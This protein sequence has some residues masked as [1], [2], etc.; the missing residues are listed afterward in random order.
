MGVRVPPPALFS[1][2]LLNMATISREQ[3]APLHERIK[4]TVSPSD[5]N[6]SFESAL[7]KYAKNANIPGFR[8]GMVPTG[9]VKKMYG[10]GVFTEEVLRKIEHELMQYLQQ[11]NISYLAQPLPED[12]NDAAQISYTEPKDYTFSFEIGLKPT[13]TIPDLAK[14]KTTLSL[15][16][17]TDEMVNEEIDRLRQ[18]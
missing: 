13:F 11:E 1:Q 2:T 8:K 18:R 10:A 6:P 9:V 16:D 3:I 7:K 14:A 4:V 15:V 5:Y 12:S 17:A